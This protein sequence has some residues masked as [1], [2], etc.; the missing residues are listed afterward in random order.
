M[1]GDHFHAPRGDDAAADDA[2][3]AGR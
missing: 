2:G 1:T 3:V